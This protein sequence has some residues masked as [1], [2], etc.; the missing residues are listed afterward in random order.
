MIT[1]EHQKCENCK[2]GRSGFDD[3]LLHCHRRSPA[4]ESDWP[5]VREHDWCG[6]WEIHPVILEES[7]D[8][9]EPEAPKRNRR[10]MRTRAVLEA[11]GWAK[12]TLYIKMNEGKFPKNFKLDPNG[13][14][15]VWWEDEV[16]KWLD[17]K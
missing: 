11:T 16:N 7:E 12:P 3:D 14:A 9:P 5:I 8:A 1:F 10:I 17:S 13:R 15:V 6:E 4:G 2:F